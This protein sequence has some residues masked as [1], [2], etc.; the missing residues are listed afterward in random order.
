[1]KIELIKRNPKDWEKDFKKQV[2]IIII[3]TLVNILFKGLTI[4]IINIYYLTQY[5]IILIIQYKQ[6]SKKD[7]EILKNKI[8][9]EKEKW[10][11][12]K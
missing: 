6:E 12:K 7:N 10:D 11:S 8:K 1:M 5:T 9:E 4:T 3:I 2:W